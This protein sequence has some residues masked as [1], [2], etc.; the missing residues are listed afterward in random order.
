MALFSNP[1]CEPFTDFS[2]DSQ[3]TSN[4][5]DLWFYPFPWKFQHWTD[6]RECQKGGRI[7]QNIKKLVLFQVQENGGKNPVAVFEDI[8]MFFFMYVFYYEVY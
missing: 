1:N 2:D 4:L 6:F 8:C 5:Y 7:F 3:I